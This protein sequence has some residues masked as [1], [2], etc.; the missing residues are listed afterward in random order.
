MPE[1]FKDVDL[2]IRIRSSQ[3]SVIDLEKLIGRIGTNLSKDDKLN[4][5]EKNLTVNQQA[6]KTLVTIVC[7]FQSID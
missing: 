2:Q 7:T 5:V 6:E 1:N 3:M 4:L